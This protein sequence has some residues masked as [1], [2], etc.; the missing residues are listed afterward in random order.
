MGS[1]YR[2]VI[3]ALPDGPRMA[4]VLEWRPAVPLADGVR[5]YAR[6]LDTHP[7][8]LPEQWPSPDDHPV[9]A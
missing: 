7:Q 5:R 2:F 4:N 8:A 6:W 1:P 9:G 3:P